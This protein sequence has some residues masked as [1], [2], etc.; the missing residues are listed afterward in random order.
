MKSRLQKNIQ[1]IFSQCLCITITGCYYHQ[2]QTNEACKLAL[3]LGYQKCVWHTL[4]CNVA[5]PGNVHTRS[6]NFQITLSLP[7][8]QK[9]WWLILQTLIQTVWSCPSYVAMWFV[10]VI[11][12]CLILTE[13]PLVLSDL[14]YGIVPSRSWLMVS[15]FVI[16][17]LPIME[18]LLPV[19]GLL[20][21]NWFRMGRLWYYTNRS[22]FWSIALTSVFGIQALSDY[23][24]L[25]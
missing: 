18:Q 13:L 19:W 8:A 6:L 21:L 4:F 22:K 2:K 10:S 16:C 9:Q 15:L 3:F 12:P 14:L 11:Y 1:Q 23:C 25:K 20:A 17:H 5:I 7:S 24:T